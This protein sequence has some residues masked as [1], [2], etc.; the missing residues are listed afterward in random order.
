VNSDIFYSNL[1]I[2]Q[3][4]YVGALTWSDIRNTSVIYE[5]AVLGWYI[6][7]GIETYQD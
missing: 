4:I 7:A 6:Q 1:Y 2:G 3:L 5:W